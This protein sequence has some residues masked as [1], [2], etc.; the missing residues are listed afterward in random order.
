MHVLHGSR[1]AASDSAVRLRSL[2]A[3]ARRF[4]AACIEN[5]VIKLTCLSAAAHAL[6]NA[7]FLRISEPLDFGM[8][9][10]LLYAMLTGEKDSMLSSCLKHRWQ[11]L[12]RPRPNLPLGGLSAARLSESGL[13][14]RDRRP[15]SHATP[16]SCAV[17]SAIGKVR[18]NSPVIRAGRAR[19]S[20]DLLPHPVELVANAAVCPTIKVTHAP[21]A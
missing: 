13:E 19:R 2:G 8:E 20:D 14:L 15:P 9:P 6:D 21:A 12:T 7:N 16:T 11:R 5:D 18:P 17:N 4:L 3:A 10:Y 1:E